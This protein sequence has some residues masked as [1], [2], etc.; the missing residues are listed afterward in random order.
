MTA[1]LKGKVAIITGAGKGIGRSIAKALAEENVKLMLFARTK[2][3]LDDVQREILKEVSQD[4][5]VT[6]FPG[7]VSDAETV[8]QVVETTIRQ[9]GRLDIVINNAGIAPQF[10]LLQELTVE[11]LDATI[12]TNLKG[13]LYMMKY[14]IPHMVQQGGGT[15]INMNS[16]AGKV[17]Y[18]YSSVYCATKFGLH[19]VTET[20]S[21]EQ[22][23]NNIKILGI[24]PG[25]VLTPIWDTIEP[26]V[27]QNPDRM[28]EPE[29]IAEAV[30]YVLKQ[31]SK[32]F[33][34]DVT[35]VP[36]SPPAH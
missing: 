31:S 32:A 1:A 36:L 22:R 7:S 13:P 26:H 23:Q 10:V 29:D 12:D 24:Y 8:A 17:P 6:V 21:E 33:V 34:K 3:D 30:R 15:I 19:A 25:E 35:L 11:Q 20:V 4:A 9:F 18:P 2:A 27:Q 14:A 28:L 16:I 5:V